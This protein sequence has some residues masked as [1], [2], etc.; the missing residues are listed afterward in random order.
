MTNRSNELDGHDS[1]ES[2]DVLFNASLEIRV[3]ERT[4][5]LK[6]ANEELE[7][8][9]IRSPMTWAPP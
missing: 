4:A 6:A 7:T 9:P 3:Q 2:L 1:S 5:A 8:F